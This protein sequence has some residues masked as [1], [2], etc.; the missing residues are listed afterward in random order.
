MP[1]I[2]WSIHKK[3]RVG[4]Q[5]QEYMTPGSLLYSLFTGR[6]RWFLKNLPISQS[7]SFSKMICMPKECLK[8]QSEQQ[9]AVNFILGASGPVPVL[10]LFITDEKIW[11]SVVSFQISGL[12]GPKNHPL[13]TEVP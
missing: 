11:R 4:I 13:V 8:V 6:E 12:L 10:Y 7:A 5:T 2:I 3:D 1:E 9:N